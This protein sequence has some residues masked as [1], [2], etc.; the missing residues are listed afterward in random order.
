MYFFASASCEVYQNG[1]AS[2]SAPAFPYARNTVIN[3]GLLG[4]NAIA[5]W[6]DG[7]GKL[8]WVADD[9]G[10][11]RFQN[12]LS[13]APEKISPPD[14][15][16]LIKAVSD[17]STLR[18]SVY[19]HAG[20]SIWVLSSPTWTWE[21]NLNTEKWNEKWSTDGTG[22]ISTRW[23]G[24]GG[25]F[26]FGKWLLGSSTT[27]NIVM[28]DDT[29]FKEENQPVTYRIESGPVQNFPN[30]TRVGRVD[31]DFDTGVGIPSGAANEQDPQVRISWSDDDGTTWK[32]PVIRKLG[33]GGK[34]LRRISVV[35]VGQTG[36]QGR[37]WRLEVT[38]A[39]Y[40]GFL[41]GVMDVDSRAK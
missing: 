29:V 34:S 7:F 19:V 39:V 28:I 17:K 5:G 31:F 10:V 20:H 21:F 16:R 11:Y 9:F 37:R 27:G 23:R 12:Y 40:V 35:G 18:A 26:A 38:D 2:I 8:I 15:D 1:G 14:L 13:F 22:L 24:D 25:I 36:V 32:V 3:R 4:A 41:G 33:L 30:R 6:E